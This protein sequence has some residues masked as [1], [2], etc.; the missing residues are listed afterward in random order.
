MK[1][2]HTI[3]L[4]PFINYYIKSLPAERHAKGKLFRHD[5]YEIRL[6]VL[7]EYS[8]AFIVFLASRGKYRHAHYIACKPYKPKCDARPSFPSRCFLLW[9]RVKRQDTSNGPIAKACECFIVGN[10]GHGECGN[11]VTE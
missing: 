6:E 1:K 2:P 11:H 5:A 10:G 3:V 4:K 8:L 9:V 7:L